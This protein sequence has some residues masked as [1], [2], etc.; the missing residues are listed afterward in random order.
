MRTLPY[1][2]LLF[3]LLFLDLFTKY[4]VE[5]N[6][7]PGEVVEVLPSFFNITLVYNPGAAFGIFGNLSDTLRR[8]CLS[9]FS[10]LAVILLLKLFFVDS[11]GDALSRFAIVA[12]LGG[13]LG[14][15]VDRI[16][17]DKVVDF[18]DFYCG[19]YHW[20]TFNIADSA[21][22]IGV[23]LLIFRMFFPREISRPISDL[24]GREK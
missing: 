9:S 19:P 23:S 8:V 12:V 15:L 21:I 24:P 22:S 20:W 17:Y 14:N 5:A 16:R 10:L 3:F 11:R 4:L 7:S 2:L 18:L 13:A 1:L 6:L